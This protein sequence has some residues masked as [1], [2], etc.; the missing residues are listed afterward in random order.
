MAGRLLVP[1]APASLGGLW[2]PTPVEAAP[3]FRFAG[4]EL[5]SSWR[6]SFAS[7]RDE[8]ISESAWP[9]EEADVMSSNAACGATASPKKSAEGRLM[10]ETGVSNPAR[11]TSPANGQATSK[12]SG[13]R[14]RNIR[15]RKEATPVRSQSRRSIYSTDC[16]LEKPE[17]KRIFCFFPN[18][19]EKTPAYANSAGSRGLLAALL[20]TAKRGSGSVRAPRSSTRSI[21]RTNVR[22]SLSRRSSRPRVAEMPL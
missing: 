7:W 11:A 9:D 2:P 14:I 15:F 18:N 1:A 13:I 22:S 4:G 3:R 21:A 6:K 20:S 12:V 19:P 10:R 8:S 5:V 17:R 16:T